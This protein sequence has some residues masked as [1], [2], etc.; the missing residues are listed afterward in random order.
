M[1][2]LAQFLFS[3]QEIHACNR[4]SAKRRRVRLVNMFGG[5]NLNASVAFLKAR[6]MSAWKLHVKGMRA[7]HPANR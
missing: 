7:H 5:N 6:W 2:A 1:V 4:Y 3:V